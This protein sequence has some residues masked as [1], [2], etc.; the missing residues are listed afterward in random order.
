MRLP[1]VIMGFHDRTHGEIGPGG[2]Q[3]RR[4]ATQLDCVLLCR[5]P[6]R[7]ER[8]LPAARHESGQQ[9]T[10][11]GSDG[12]GVSGHR[13]EAGTLG[14]VGDD[15]HDRDPAR[16]GVLERR[17]QRRWVPRRDDQAAR[18]LAQGGFEQRDVAVAKR[19]IR[20]EV[21]L[22]RR[23]ERRRGLA[24]AFAQRIPEERNPPGQM[25]ADAELLPR[26]QVAGREVGTVAQRLRHARGRG[27]EWRR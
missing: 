26:L 4:E 27:R 5:Q 17:G 23:R 14:R 6:A 16:C 20:V 24:N 9:L 2:I 15:T 3:A 10:G 8:H 21:D 11:D 19:R 1:L 18:T 12:E 22:Q 25:N 13:C 7:E